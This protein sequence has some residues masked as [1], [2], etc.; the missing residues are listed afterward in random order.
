MN[1]GLLIVISGPSGVGK[2]TVLKEVFKKDENLVYSVSCTTRQ[3]RPGETDGIEY[4][5]ISVEKF[6][7]NIADGKMLEYA[8]YCDNFYGTNAEYVEKQRELGKDV[9]LEIETQ[10]A[11][12]IIDKCDDAISIFI[13]PPSLEILKKRLSGRGT[14]EQSIIDQRI[15]TAIG[16]LN[17]MSKYEYVVINDDLESAVDDVAA[18]LRAERIKLNKNKF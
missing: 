18:V 9:V 5:F 12:Q 16:E 7:Q 15:E 3:P 8:Q 6:K 14:E 13:A 11:M 10:G 4:H 2:G 1:K 17:L